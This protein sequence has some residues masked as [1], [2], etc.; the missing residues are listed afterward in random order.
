M[1]DGDK[2]EDEQ[3]KM[4]LSKSHFAMFN[5]E[6]KNSYINYVSLTLRYKIKTTHKNIFDHI[7]VK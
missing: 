4:Q 3:K 1:F 5:F 6:F 2:N 7:F